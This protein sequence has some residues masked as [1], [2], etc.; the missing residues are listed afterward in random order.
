ME[1]FGG[2]LFTL[3]ILICCSAFTYCLGVDNANYD[4]KKDI[5]QINSYSKEEL[6][7]CTNK[8]LDEVIIKFARK[9]K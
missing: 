2:L 6:T 9:S 4:I 5:C 1:A 7:A 3:G 8:T